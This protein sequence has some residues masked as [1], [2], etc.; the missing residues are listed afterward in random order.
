MPVL[1]GHPRWECQSEEKCHRKILW[2]IDLRFEGER[3]ETLYIQSGS[4]FTGTNG[5]LDN[6]IPR[7]LC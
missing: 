5:G 2:Q 3:H 4:C 6:T 7:P 1:H